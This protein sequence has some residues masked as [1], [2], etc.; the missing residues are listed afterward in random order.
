MAKRRPY[1]EWTP[2]GAGFKVS[3]GD[4]E[5]NQAAAVLDYD[6]GWVDFT[7]PANWHELRFKPTWFEVYEAPE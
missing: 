7:D 6:D 3:L 2:L 4:D 5:G 1:S